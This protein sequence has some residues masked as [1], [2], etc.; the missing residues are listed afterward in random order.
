[1]ATASAKT[2]VPARNRYGDHRHAG[3]DG[4]RAKAG[5]RYSFGIAEIV[6]VET[7]FSHANVSGAVCGSR[8]IRSA[9]IRGGVRVQPFGPIDQL[10]FPLFPPA[11]SPRA[12]G[13]PA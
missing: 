4:E 11:A 9:V 6:G 12:P 3:T 5:G 1:M 8:M 13:P 10:Q 7:Q 2:A